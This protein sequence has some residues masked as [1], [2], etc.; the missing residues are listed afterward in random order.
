VSVS[1]F[2]VTGLPHGG[3]YAHQ[4]YIG[5]D[6]DVDTDAIQRILD[7]ELVRVNDD[8]G[9]ERKYAL[10]YMFVRVLPN[11]VF[12]DYL[13][14]IGKAGGQSKFPRV[15]KGQ[16]HEGWVEYLRGRGMI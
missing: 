8:Y 9:I 13:A 10:A 15:L 12:I 11:Q 16:Q 4:W 7:E 5:C 1:E 2:A 14:R 3:S 6:E